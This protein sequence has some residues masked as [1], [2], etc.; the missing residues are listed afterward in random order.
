MRRRN[1]KLTDIQEGNDPFAKRALNDEQQNPLGEIEP[2]KGMV[3]IEEEKVIPTKLAIDN[4]I[5][6]LQDLV[7]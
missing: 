7:V 6:G 3:F 1:S 5:D 4:K 2:K